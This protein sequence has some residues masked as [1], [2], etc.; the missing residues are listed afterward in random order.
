MNLAKAIQDLNSSVNKFF[1]YISSI[2]YWGGIP[3]D[4][5]LHVVVGF[6]VTFIGLK[7]KFSFLRVFLFLL[8]IESLKAFHAA[9]TIDHDIL[10]GMKEFFATFTYPAILWVIRKVKE[11]KQTNQK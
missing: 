11:K 9:M 2:T 4:T 5:T 7:L 3:L 8:F 1:G 10:H 6:L